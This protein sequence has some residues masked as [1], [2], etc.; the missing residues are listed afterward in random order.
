MLREGR[1]AALHPRRA[2]TTSSTRTRSSSWPAPS[3][4]EEDLYLK[5]DGEQP[6]GSVVEE[7]PQGYV[8][9]REEAPADDP[10]TEDDES[11]TG[12]SRLVPPHATAP[13]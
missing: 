1:R 3:R 10:A 9:L 6:E 7:V 5:F 4:K 8:V 2:S 13:S 11:E 12:H